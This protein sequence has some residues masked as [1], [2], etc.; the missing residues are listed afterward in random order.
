MLNRKAILT[1]TGSVVLALTLSGCSSLGSLMGLGPKKPA[2]YR[3][4]QIKWVDAKQRWVSVKHDKPISATDVSEKAWTAKKRGIMLKLKASKNLNLYDGAAHT[5][6]V[7][8]Y[9]ATDPN[10]FLQYFRSRAGVRDLLE[11]AKPDPTEVASN[12]YFVQPGGSML[13][14]ID[15]AATARDVVIVAA[16][17]SLAPA[18]TTR[19]IGIPGVT[20][21]PSGIAKLK[22]KNILTTLNP[23]ASYPP[24]RPAVL[25]VDLTLGG[26][27]IAK[28]GVTAR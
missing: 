18:G 7:R 9:Q 28:M 13:V 1:L 26:K 6:M 19:I 5:L 4:D 27:A 3:P 20:E 12:T 17:Y 8:V 14:P 15:R 16:Y 11:E 10:T 23:L 22:A 21:R 24:P 2:Q 25:D